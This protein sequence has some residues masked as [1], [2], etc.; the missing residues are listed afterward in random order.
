MSCRAWGKRVAW[1][2]CRNRERGAPRLSLSYPQ[3]LIAVG[4]QC[5]TSRPSRH[6]LSGSVSSVTFAHTRTHRRSRFGSTAPGRTRAAARAVLSSAGQEGRSPLRSGVYLC[7]ILLELRGDCI[8]FCFFNYV[9]LGWWHFGI[10]MFPSLLVCPNCP[11]WAA[12][13]NQ[14]IQVCGGGW[15]QA[16]WIRS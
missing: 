2:E 15:T 3:H 1:A 14:H 9:F 13:Q 12:V 11:Q 7:L 10:L 4:S 5:P 8:L 6:P 16:S